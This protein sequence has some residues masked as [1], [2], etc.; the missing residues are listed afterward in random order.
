MAQM[1][2][3]VHLRRAYGF[4]QEVEKATQEFRDQALEH[5]AQ[6]ERDQPFLEGMVS[7]FKGSR[8]M[9]RQKT[10]LVGDLQLASQEI[11]RASALDGNTVIETESG[12]LGVIQLR[13][14]VSYMSGQIE[15]IWGSGDEAKRLF[16][17]SLQLVEL[18]H[19]HFM[20]G[21]LC[22]SEYRPVEALE[23]FEKCLDL[24]PNG[25]FSVSALREA[26]AM[27]NYKK[28]FRGSWLLV[29]IFCFVPLPPFL[30]GILYF[31]FK[32]K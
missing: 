30:W 12:D 16:I 28:K 31:V 23:H 32:R 5:D 29:L 25:E 15:M 6:V 14:L 3:D 8:Q 22:E 9:K 21:I 13:G 27:R 4:I 20:L 7:S 1:T 2:A 18:P 24:D 26:N 17:A 19:T 11:D 10:A